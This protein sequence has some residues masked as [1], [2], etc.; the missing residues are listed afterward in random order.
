MLDGDVVVYF[1]VHF[2][3]ASSQ[4]GGSTGL[5]KR[6]TRSEAVWVLSPALILVAHRQLAE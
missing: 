2:Y 6:G 3:P 4:A 5:H 1:S